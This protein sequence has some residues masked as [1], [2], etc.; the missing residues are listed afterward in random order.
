MKPGSLMSDATVQ[1][2]RNSLSCVRLLHRDALLV[3]LFAMTLIRRQ[4]VWR[5]SCPDE[6]PPWS[7]SATSTASTSSFSLSRRPT[8][9]SSP[10]WR[11]FSRAITKIIYFYVLVIFVVV[12]PVEC[13]FCELTLQFFDAEHFIWRLVLDLE[14]RVDENCESVEIRIWNM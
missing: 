12:L 4:D 13:S 9:F 2:L 6:A 10:V 8:S 7:L 14:L 5:S 11:C 1:T 3:Q